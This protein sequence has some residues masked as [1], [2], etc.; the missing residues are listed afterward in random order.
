MPLIPRHLRIPAAALLI[1]VLAAVYTLF[2]LNRPLPPIAPRQLVASAQAAPGDRPRVPWPTGGIAAIGAT[3]LG[4]I[5]AS[6]GERTLPMA[7]IAKVMTATVVLADHPL[8]PQEQGP[9]ITITDADVTEYQR[10][11]AAGESVVE[12]RAGEQLTEYQALQALL[13]PSG[14][15]IALVLANW[16]AGGLQPF[17]AKLNARA[18]ALAMRSTVFADA[19]GFDENTR[20]TPSDLTRLAAAVIRDPV[21]AEIVSTPN[22]KIPVAGTVYNVD[23]DLGQGGID[24]IKTGSD[25]A[26]GACFMFSSA[27]RIAGHPVTIVGTVMALPQ[28][29][30]AFAAAKRLIDFVKQG[31]VYDSALK[32]GQAVAEYVAPWGQTSVLRA[33][34]AVYL[35]EWPGL[36]VERSLS[37]GAAPVP[38]TSG[39]VQGAVEVRLGEQDFRVPLSADGGLSPPGKGWRLK[40]LL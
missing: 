37:V 14:N 31:L 30:D 6:P 10:A 40:R 27:F 12:V 28:L 22:A 36:K 39:A 34:D 16:D 1:V 23:Y 19:S 17:V 13:I 25:P 26:A 2:Q 4:V 20:A 24:G 8:K 35:V 3:E 29:D 15:N 18:K 7:S 5:E 11:K 33:T 32:S 38:L 9:L 21:F